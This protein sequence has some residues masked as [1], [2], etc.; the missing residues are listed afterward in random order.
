MTLILSPTRPGQ[1]LICL[2][3][4]LILAGTMGYASRCIAM[5][6]PA[7]HAAQAD[8]DQGRA[9]DAIRRLTDA[10]A[11]D[12][13]DG[14]AHNLLCRAY[15]EE[16]RLD[17]AVHECEQAIRLAPDSSTNHLWLGRI[18]GEKAGHAS[19]FAAYGLSK[20]IRNE[21]ETAVR[22]D[23]RNV[24]ALVDQ[25]QFYTEAPSM[26][27]GGTDKASAVAA[28][29]DAINSSQGHELRARIAA[30]QKDYPRAESEFKAAVAATKS[31]AL[32][33][34][35][36]A[37]FYRKQQRWDDMMHAIR[38]AIATDRE[39]GVA[40]TYA[41]SLLVRTDRE[42]QLAIHLLQ[43]YLASPNK[44]EQA[45]AFQVR[46]RLGQLL[47]QQGDTQGAQKEFDAA[48]AMAHD[49]KVPTRPANKSG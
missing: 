19:Y 16:E 1:P 29:L 26:V 49:Y 11:K 4:C 27:G 32:V 3:I 25:A 47:L 46:A 9:D 14:Q 36:L 17:S 21:F 7:A 28:K 2:A 13:K 10:L 24:D 22:L 35:S 31:P 42:P 23:P 37:S 39:R 20:K 48:K 43:E 12:A 41:A 5:D 34:T 38:Q 8:L 33:W 44:S 30:Q 6:G 18:Y 45:P 40:L 15:F